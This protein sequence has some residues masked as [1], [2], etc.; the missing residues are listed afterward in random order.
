MSIER[1]ATGV[2]S[3][4]ATGMSAGVAAALANGS[5][6]L[7]DLALTNGSSTVNFDVFA[8]VSIS[9]L[10]STG[11]VAAP[12]FFGIYLY[13]LNEDGTTYGAGN[14]TTSPAVV[15]PQSQYYGG[16]VSIATSSSAQMVGTVNRIVLPPGAFKFVV[17]NQSGATTSTCLVLKY[18]SYNRAVTAT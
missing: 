18:Q 16:S 13:P 1:W 9:A 6:V 7:G 8:D 12:Y 5:S 4:W 2:T 17:Y 15:V 3:G 10:V 11:L 14:L